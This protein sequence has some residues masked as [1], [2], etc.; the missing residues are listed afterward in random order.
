M[1]RLMLTTAI[2]LLACGMA[3]GKGITVTY[4]N[5]GERLKVGDRVN[6]TWKAFG[7]SN[8]VD[9]LLK[10]KKAVSQLKVIA[11]SINW[12]ACSFRWKVGQTRT[13]VV[14][15]GS[16]YQIVIRER[17]TKTSDMSNAS[18]SI[19]S[20]SIGKGKEGL[21]QHTAISQSRRAPLPSLRVTSP[22]NRHALSLDS[23]VRI[24]WTA[25]DIPSGKK[26][27]LDLFQ[28]DR[29]VGIIEWDLDKDRISHVW[30]V[31]ELKAGR[32]VTPGANYK[33]K[34]Y[35]QPRPGTYHAWSLPFVIEDERNVD[36]WVRVDNHEIIDD[37]RKVQARICYGRNTPGDP[38]PDLKLF[39]YLRLDNGDRTLI[40]TKVHHTG[41]LE[42]RGRDVELVIF[43]DLQFGEYAERGGSGTH[44]RFILSATI[45][46]EARVRDSNLSNNSHEYRFS[47]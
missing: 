3:Y 43:K 1:R 2:L 19:Q 22:T 27:S 16:D 25:K 34:V 20:R 14:P 13:G 23:R 36:I 29:F 46:P 41:S 28:G 30:R 47:Y 8:D 45:D 11:S 44:R 32:V 4:P 17:S 7:L 39:Y 38:L 12:K 21:S 33:I 24:G 10:N 5:G 6:I 26:L 18:F 31:G 40:D 15:A 9:I 42:Y 37:G 35:I